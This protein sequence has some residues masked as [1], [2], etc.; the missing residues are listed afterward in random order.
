MFRFAVLLLVPGVLVCS[1]DIPPTTPPSPNYY[2][3]LR[4]GNLSDLHD[5]SAQ[6]KRV[7]KEN[8]SLPWECHS[9]SN[10]IEFP[11][12]PGQIAK[13]KSIDLVPGRGEVRCLG[14]SVQVV[15][16]VRVSAWEGEAPQCPGYFTSTT[17]LDTGSRGNAT[18]KFEIIPKTLFHVYDRPPTEKCAVQ[19]T[20]FIKPPR[21]AFGYRGGRVSDCAVTG[22]HRML[23]D[24]NMTISTGDGT[25]EIAT[26]AGATAIKV[27]GFIWVMQVKRIECR[28]ECRIKDNS[29]GQR[30]SDTLG[31]TVFSNYGEEGGLVASSTTSP[32]QLI[33]GEGSSVLLVLVYVLAFLLFLTT[34]TTV[35]FLHVSRRLYRRLKAVGHEPQEVKSPLPSH[36]ISTSHS[37]S[38]HRPSAHHAP[39]LHANHG[40][41]TTCHAAS[42]C[43]VNNSRRHLGA[44]T[45]PACFTEGHYSTLHG[46][47][48]ECHHYNTV[49]LRLSDC[50]EL[51]GNKSES[52]EKPIY[53]KLNFAEAE[54]VPNANAN[55]TSV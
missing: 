24:C 45:S 29:S 38:F 46:F 54:K 53:Q 17:Q 21:V 47:R 28:C 8:S 36:R 20:A 37:P 51:P 31:Y 6:F 43:R 19:E 3:V 11:E 34:I 44:S 23:L 22:E 48:N 10:P 18:V 16:R 12:G 9:G 55:S 39:T 5:T 49:S 52:K 30:R 13:A 15:E 2:I 4:V 42:R 40:A 32:N 50:F 14:L 27:P 33:S 41:N 1:S 7:E 35:I 26:A 25:D